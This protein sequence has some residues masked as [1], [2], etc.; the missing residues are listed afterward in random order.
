MKYSQIILFLPLFFLL[1]SCGRPRKIESLSNQDL[2]VLEY[3]PKGQQ[4]PINLDS[5]RIRFASQVTF[6]FDIHPQVDGR[7]IYEPSSRTVVFKILSTLSYNTKY[8]V[9]TRAKDIYSNKSTEFSWEFI[10]VSQDNVLYSVY[11]PKC[12]RDK[13]LVEVS[14]PSLSSV[15]VYSNSLKVIDTVLSGGDWGFEFSENLKEGENIIEVEITP[16]EFISTPQSYYWN[17][18]SIK[19]TQNPTAP[20]IY[21]RSPFEF[22]VE[23]SYDNCGI[24]GE[25]LLF[26]IENDNQEFVGSVPN[27]FDTFQIAFEGGEICVKAVDI[28]GNVSDCSNKIKQGFDIKELNLDPSVESVIPKWGKIF[29]IKNKQLMYTTDGTDFNTTG[30][31]CNKIFPNLSRILC[32]VDEKIIVLDKDMKSQELYGYSVSDSCSFSDFFSDGTSVVG[33]VAIPIPVQKIACSQDYIMGYG[34]GDF[35]LTDKNEIWKKEATAIS[36]LGTQILDASSEIVQIFPVN[37]TFVI[38][39]ENLDF[40]RLLSK[41]I[42]SYVEQEFGKISLLIWMDLYDVVYAKEYR[43]QNFTKF[44]FFKGLTIFLTKDQKILVDPKPFSRGDTTRVIYNNVKDIGVS[45]FDGNSSQEFFILFS[46][47]SL[48]IVQ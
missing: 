7:I 35:Y 19:D 34:G 46:D 36:Y 20:K 38:L 26:H 4:V 22:Y 14:F 15:S 43:L 28:V 13:I 27:E 37:S 44:L 2:E 32:Q 1:F 41:I 33:D 47:G 21:R 23:G 17:L 12:F 5:I 16:L 8:K 9:R 39:F 3:F 25:F 29:F 40:S 11:V 18:S 42:G 30:I 24:T 45:D 10:T 6:S 48:K 31:L